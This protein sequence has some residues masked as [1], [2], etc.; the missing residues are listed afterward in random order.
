MLLVD[1]DEVR[2]MTELARSMINNKKLDFMDIDQPSL[3]Q[4]YFLS[5]VVAL[6]TRSPVLISPTLCKEEFVGC[7]NR[8][9]SRKLKKRTLPSKLRSLFKRVITKMII[10]LAFPRGEPSCLLPA[11]YRLPLLPEELKPYGNTHVLLEEYFVK[12]HQDYAKHLLNTNHASCLKVKSLFSLSPKFKEEF[13]SI[14]DGDEIIDYVRFDATNTYR[15]MLE[16]CY[17]SKAI[18]GSSNA[19]Q[20]CCLVST[21]KQVPE[22][23]CDALETIHY[24]KWNCRD[25]VMPSELSESLTRASSSITTPS[26]KPKARLPLF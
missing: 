1:P 8:R 13:C 9:L 19:G 16:M 10:T 14:L 12:D 15:Q 23:E 3:Q 6:A 21:F 2:T 5:N 25:R 20:T 7:V 4:K 22:T 17:R 26:S 11:G 18:E 24:L